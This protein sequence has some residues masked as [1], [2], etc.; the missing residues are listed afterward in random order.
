ML[1]A[2]N[3]DKIL[4]IVPLLTIILL[5]MLGAIAAYTGGSSPI[6][7]ATRICFWGII[8]MGLTYIAGSLFNI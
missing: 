3:L 1:H 5:G 4:Y 7:G 8:A 2:N 6:K